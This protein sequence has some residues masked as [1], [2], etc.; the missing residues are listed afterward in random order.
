MSRALLRHEQAFWENV[1]SDDNRVGQGSNT[2]SMQVFYFRGKKRK[3]PG[4][5]SSHKSANKINKWL[6]QALLQNRLLTL[7]PLLL[8]APFSL[9]LGTCLDRHKILGPTLRSP[10]A[11]NSRKNV[12]KSL[13][14]ILTLTIACA[15]LVAFRISELAPL[16]MFSFP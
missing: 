14:I 12:E 13:V 15:V 4:F 11:K 8:F 7:W 5:T 1:M 6:S 9:D 10:I 3:C 2:Y 16:E